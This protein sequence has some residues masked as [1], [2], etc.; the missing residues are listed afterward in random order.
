MAY[1]ALKQ[2]LNDI[3]FE[4]KTMYWGVGVFKKSRRSLTRGCLMMKLWKESKSSLT[5]IR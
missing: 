5:H 1:G 3:E 2:Q 4:Y